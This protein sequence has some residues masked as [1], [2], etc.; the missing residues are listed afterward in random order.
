MHPGAPSK[1]D[2]K[3]TLFLEHTTL[4]CRGRLLLLNKPLVMGILNITPDS[5]YD[6]GRY[7]TPSQAADRVEHM[8][9][10]GADLIDVGAVSTRPGSTPPNSKEELARLMPVLHEVMKRV[11]EAIISVDTFRSEVAKAAVAEGASIIND[12]SSGEMD[13][14]MFETIA[15]LQ[16][17]YVLMHMQGTPDTMQHAPRYAHV[18]KEVTQWLASR[19]QQLRTLGVNDIIADPGFGFGKT[20]QHNYTLLRELHYLSILQVPLMVGISRKSMVYKPL[21]STPEESLVGTTALH[22]HALTKGA[23]ILRVHD[24]KAAKETTKLYSLIHHHKNNNEVT[25]ISEKSS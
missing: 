18:T 23:H 24:V 6:G 25:G 13:H 9:N 2:A 21:E 7:L 20:L 14:Q 12:I 3:S 19:I 8:L 1:I 22:Y 16:V 11:P 15:A 10:E 17:P 4:R 5:F